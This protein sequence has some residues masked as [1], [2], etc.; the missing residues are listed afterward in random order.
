MVKIKPFIMLWYDVVQTTNNNCFK[1]F[2]ESAF[3][4]YSSTI[5]F[6]HDNVNFGSQYRLFNDVACNVELIL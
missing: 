1:C 5:I 6:L 4:L 2:D 3:Q